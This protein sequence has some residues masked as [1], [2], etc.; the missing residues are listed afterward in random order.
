MSIRK[1][2]EAVKQP[3][4]ENKSV[5]QPKDVKTDYTRWRLVDERGRQTWE[6]LASDEKAKQWTQTTADKYHVGLN[7]VC[8]SF[9]FP[10]GCCL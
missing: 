1:R 3:N 10:Q 6:Y 5:E 8:W 9:G 4:G 2:G 7:T